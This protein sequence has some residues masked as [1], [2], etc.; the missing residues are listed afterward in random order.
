LTPFDKTLCHFGRS[1][2]EADAKRLVNLARQTL[3]AVTSNRETFLDFDSFSQGTSACDLGIYDFVIHLKPLQVPQ[4]K[5]RKATVS[6]PAFHVVDYNP[7]ASYLSELKE[8]FSDVA[9]FYYGNGSSVIGVKLEKNAIDQ[10]PV[11]SFKHSAGKFVVKNRLVCNI[12]AMV[13]DFRILGQDFVK[14]IECQ[15]GGKRE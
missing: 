13:E 2:R 1:I 14:E 3:H 6:G 12:E 15:I 10:V 4:M 5:E 7:V 11:E 8:C 9:H